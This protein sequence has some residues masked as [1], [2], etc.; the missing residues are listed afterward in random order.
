MKATVRLGSIGR[1]SIIMEGLA[2]STCR[3][4]TRYA[5][6]EPQAYGKVCRPNS[7][8]THLVR[9]VVRLVPYWHLGDTRQVHQ[10][11]GAAKGGRLQRIQL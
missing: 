9:Y 8:G 2:G 10:R 11:H 3:W 5:Q 6:R 1:F 4:R 7:G